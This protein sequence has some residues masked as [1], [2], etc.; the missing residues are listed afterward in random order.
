[1]HAVLGG[2]GGHGGGEEAEQGDLD[3]RPGQGNPLAGP[4]WQGGEGDRG[5]YEPEGDQ[6]PPGP[7][8]GDEQPVDHGHGGDGQRPADPYR[9]LEDVDEGDQGPGVAAEGQPSP[10]VGAALVGEGGAE[11]GDD[12]PGGHEEQG[13]DQGQPG[14]RLGAAPGHRPQGVEDHDGR[15]QQADGVQAPQ[16]AAELG[17]LG[18]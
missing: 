3:G 4:Q 13:R 15:N 2:V 9:R 16:L 11:L 10:D 6:D 5:P 7:A 18:P 1:V 8:D 17:P 12:Q 14:Q